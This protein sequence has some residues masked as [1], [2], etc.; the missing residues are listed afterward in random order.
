MSYTVV[1]RIA[2]KKWRV[3]PLLLGKLPVISMA[4]LANIAIAGI[5]CHSVTSGETLPIDA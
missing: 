4:K 5:N 1:P 2:R 3:A